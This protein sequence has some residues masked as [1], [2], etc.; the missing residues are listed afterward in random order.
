MD[1]S[2]DSPRR[3]VRALGI[4]ATGLMSGAERVLLRHALDGDRAGIEWTIACADGAFADA[5]TAAGIKRIRLGD[6][7]LGDRSRMVALG[8]LG[9]RNLKAVPRIRRAVR[10]TDVVV[11][12]SVLCLPLLRVAVPRSIPTIWL[13]H[14]VIVR[15]DL[16]AVAQACRSAVSLAA[17]VSE[18]AAALPRQ[19]GMVSTVIRN[20]VRFPVAEASPHANPPIVGINAILTEW[21]GQRELLEAMRLVEPDFT[22]EILGGMFP[23]DRHYG[24]QLREL[25]SDARLV[26]R[27]KFLGHQDNPLDVMRRWSV[28]VSASIEPEAG[29]LAVLEAMSIGLPV[30]VT[31]HGGAPEIAKEVGVLVPPGDIPALANA[32][33]TLLRDPA[34]CVRRGREGR[35]LVALRHTLA[36]SQEMFSKAVHDLAGRS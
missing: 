8:A 18:A 6:L 11:A 10:Q 7:K 2:S 14:D 28:A 4:S 15:R 23:K 29:P 3:T 12:N 24:Q 19:I 35:G 16:R 34:E 5:V 26:K 22:L 13:V 21:K 33:E 1:M 25:A 36:Q 27:V 31:D 30:V 32:I 20:G 9:F 17:G